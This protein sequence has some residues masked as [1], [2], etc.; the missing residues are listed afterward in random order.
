MAMPIGRRHWFGDWDVS[1]TY[2]AI[3]WGAVAMVAAGLLAAMIPATHPAWRFGVVAVAVALF[4]AVAVDWTSLAATAVI[5]FLIA[6]GFLEDRLGQLAWHGGADAWRVL[7]LVAAG[8]AGTAAGYGGRA[9]VAWRDRQR[10]AVAAAAVTL[11]A[12]TSGVPPAG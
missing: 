1:R 5:G 8:V 2:P 3:G 6:N 7:A 9:A 4:A 11:P 10:A 12:R